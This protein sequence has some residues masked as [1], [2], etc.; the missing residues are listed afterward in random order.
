M[1]IASRQPWSEYVLL[2]LSKASLNNLTHSYEPHTV[3]VLD[4]SVKC[5]SALGKP[6]N[7]HAVEQ[8]VIVNSKSF[9]AL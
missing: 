9:K 3:T 8:P 4:R 2:Y 6:T 1:V 5:V 7:V